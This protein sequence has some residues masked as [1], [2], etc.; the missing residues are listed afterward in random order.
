MKPPFKRIPIEYQQ[1]QMSPSNIF[2][3]LKSDHECYLYLFSTRE[4]ERRCHEDLSFMYIA[5]MNCP[6]FREL[7][8]FRENNAAL[9]KGNY[10]PPATRYTAPRCNASGGAPRR[11][12]ARTRGAERQQTGYTAERCNQALLRRDACLRQRDTAA[13]GE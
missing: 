4:I 6:N 3:L 7:S 2:D 1:R 9:F 12:H 5:T 10:S 13:G 8:N 11:V